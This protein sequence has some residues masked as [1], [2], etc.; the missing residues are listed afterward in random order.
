MSQEDSSNE[1]AAGKEQG[2]KDPTAERITLGISVLI[3]LGLAALVIYQQVVGGTQPPVIEVQPKLEEIRREG[4]AYYVPID[5][6]NK[7]E[8]TAEDIE[9]QMSLEVEGEEPETIAFAVKF[10]AGGETGQQTV[11]F[12]NDPAEGKLTHLVAFTT[13]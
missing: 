11:V 1:Q 4:D 12:Q 5:I 2:K 9:I 8:L 13:P 7:G 6:A 10:L 3:V